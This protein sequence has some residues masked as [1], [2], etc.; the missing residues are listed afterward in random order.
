MNSTLGIIRI[1]LPII[2][3]KSCLTPDPLDVTS[4]NGYFRFEVRVE[5]SQPFYYA[6]FK[7]KEI[8][9]KSLIGFKYSG[10]ENIQHKITIKAIKKSTRY[11]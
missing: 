8:I 3:L 9:G 10:K 2:F 1:F 6:Y 7:N 4:P 5:N 11:R